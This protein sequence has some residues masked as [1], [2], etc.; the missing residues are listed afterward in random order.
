M[1]KYNRHLDATNQNS[2]PPLH[3]HA[4]YQP[5]CVFVHTSGS[6]LFHSDCVSTHAELWILLWGAYSC[7]NGSVG[8]S[9]FSLLNPSVT[10]T[11][12]WDLA[13]G[14]TVTAGAYNG[15][16]AAGEGFFRDCGFSRS[17]L[18]PLEGGSQLV[19]GRNA[20]LSHLFEVRSAYQR[21][22][23]EHSQSVT[24]QD[25]GEERSLVMSHTLWTG[26]GIMA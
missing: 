11:H 14:G 24:M 3:K 9:S 15:E 7:L 12:I 10:G 8:L 2:P 4:L 22:F 5:L 20:N 19:V 17:I 26:K 6:V 25:R 21:V 23:P 18:V 1:N 13:R 16:P